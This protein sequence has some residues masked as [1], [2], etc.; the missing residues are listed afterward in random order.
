MYFCGYPN[1]LVVTQTYRTILIRVEV[2]YVFVFANI[3]TNTAYFYWYLITFQTMYLHLYLSHRIW[4]IWQICLQ[5]HFI[6][7]PFSKHK[8]MD[9]KLTWI[10]FI[11]TL[12]SGILFQNKCRGLTILIP[13]GDCAC[14]LDLACQWVC[15]KPSPLLYWHGPLCNANWASKFR[16]VS[17]KT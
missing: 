9:H 14:A 8:Y 10:S 7:G 16:M 12:K 11:N 5:I 2:K 1:I 6:P 13:I 15:D 3:D 4:C 17:Y